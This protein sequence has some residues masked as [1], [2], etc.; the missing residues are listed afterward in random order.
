MSGMMEHIYLSQQELPIQHHF[1]VAED[2]IAQ[3]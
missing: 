3:P 1:K 2:M